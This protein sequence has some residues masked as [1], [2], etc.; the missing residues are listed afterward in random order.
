MKIFITGSTGFIG[1]NLVSYFKDHNVFAYTRDMSLADELIKFK[2]ALII[3]SAAEIYNKDKMLL[4]NVGIPHVCLEYVKANPTCS[5]IQLGTSS[6]YG[7]LNRASKETDRVK[8]KDEYAVSKVAAT[9]MCQ[10]YAMIHNLDVVVVRPYSPFGPDEQSHRLFPNLWRSFTLGTP[11]KLVNGVHDF[12]YIDDFVEAI[13]LIV[14][15]DKR[16]PG[17]IINVS[18]GVQ[19]SNIDVLNAFKHVS[20]KQGNVTLEDRFV[21]PPVWKCNNKLIKTK[22]NWIPAHTLAQGIE[23]FLAKAKYE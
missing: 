5:M 19:S 1:K 22:Y 15:S 12:C 7:P 21:T 18:S 8:P 17:E 6:E 23:K 10:K 4:A 16:T 3:N 11:M 9:I 13:G 2:P 20:G 14:A